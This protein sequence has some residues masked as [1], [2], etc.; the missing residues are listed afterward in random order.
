MQ[1]V[2]MLNQDKLFKTYLMS[3]SS[4]DTIVRV[5]IPITIRKMNVSYSNRMNE[6]SLTTSFLQGCSNLSLH[7][8]GSLQEEPNSGTLLAILE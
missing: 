6:E 2:L 3:N 7:I 5:I 4:N 1:T 8:T